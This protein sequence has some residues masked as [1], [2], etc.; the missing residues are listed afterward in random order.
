MPGLAG[1][2]A[3]VAA[4]PGPS[5]DQVAGA[6]GMAPADRQAMI[7]NMV[8]GL[9]KRLAANPKDE[10]GWVRL[11]RSRQV[12]GDMGAASAAKADALRAFGDD[13]AATARIK[14]AA[15]E[16]GL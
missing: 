10:A 3:G 7:T 15:T 5:A 4:T 16:M 14:A 13:P 11:M 9:A 6:Q 1:V 12:L 2:A 8:D